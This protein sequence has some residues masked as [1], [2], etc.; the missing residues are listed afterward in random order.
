MYST[1]CWGS[2]TYSVGWLGQVHVEYGLPGIAIL[3]VGWGSYM[4]NTGC[5]R[6]LHVQYQLP[7]AATCTVLVAWDS[8]MYSTDFRA[9]YVYNTN[10]WSSYVYSTDC[11]RQL[12]VQYG[13]MF[14][15]AVILKRQLMMIMTMNLIA[16][17][18]ICSRNAREKAA[19]LAM[20]IRLC[21]PRYGY[22]TAV[23]A[24]ATFS[25]F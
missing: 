12:F 25:I 11:R 18:P 23:L 7:G 21:C 2:Y 1:G 13:L 3:R 17:F 19:V 5:M 14:T 6:Q 8:Y 10:C 24:T 22:K 15:N 16:W 4:Y 20:A 9:S